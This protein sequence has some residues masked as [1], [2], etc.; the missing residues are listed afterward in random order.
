MAEENIQKTIAEFEQNRAQ[1]VSVSSQ[2]QQ[3][4]LH[5]KTLEAALNELKNTKEK[6]VYKAVGNILILSDVAAVDKELKEQKDSVDLRIKTLQKQE[7]LLVD[8]LN[9][10]KSA[11][12][13]TQKPKKE[14]E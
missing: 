3:L 6:K 9:K 14:A 10:L 2:K 13:S 8:K 1:L 5:V 11:I 4:Q 7:D 12:E